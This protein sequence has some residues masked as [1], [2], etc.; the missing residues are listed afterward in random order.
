[1]FCLPVSLRDRNSTA[2]K[3][4]F[5]SHRNTSSSYCLPELL[6]SLCSQLVCFSFSLFSSQGL[7][8]AW[9][10]TPWWPQ[11]KTTCLCLS[12]WDCYYHSHIVLTE[13]F[14]GLYP[15]V[16]YLQWFFFPFCLYVEHEHVWYVYLSM[17][18]DSSV[19]LVLP[20]HTQTWEASQSHLWVLTSLTSQ[21]SP[22]ILTFQFSWAQG[23]YKIITMP[24]IG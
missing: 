10:S 13:S 23:K 2:W 17:A 21:L 22:S 18:Q 1:M 9:L 7:Y 6:S 14:Y 19:E 4:P 15:W 3:N 11:L 12:Y 24:V 16:S 5:T 8:V 20:F